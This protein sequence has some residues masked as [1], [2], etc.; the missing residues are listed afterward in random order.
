LPTINYADSNIKF[1]SKDELDKYLQTYNLEGIDSQF[2]KNTEELIFL[3][4]AKGAHF[5]KWWV[6]TP[7]TWKCPACE[8]QKSEIVRLNKHQDL[9][10]TLHE[11][12]DHM[13]DLVKKRFEE[14]SSKK[15]KVV[16]DEF[17]EKFSIRLSFA[18]ASYDNTVV[19]SDCNDADTKAKALAKTHTDFSYSPDDIKQ[20]IIVKNNTEHEINS[21]VAINIWNNQKDTFKLRM[22]FLNS[23]AAIA[24]DNKNWYKPSKKTAK[25]TESLGK[26]YIKKYGLD[27]IQY[28]PEKLLYKTYIYKGS[29]DKWRYTK[30]YKH[31]KLPTSGDIQHLSQTRGK[32][33]NDIDDSWI[34]PICER[35]KINCIQPSKKNPWVFLTVNKSFYDD[36]ELEYNNKKTICHECHRVS[37]HLHK[38]VDINSEID[39]AYYGLITQE[40]LKNCITSFKHNKHEIDNDYVNNLLYDLDN[41]FQY[42]KF[43]LET[44]E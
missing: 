43:Q 8:R 18:L 4:K 39:L 22:E 5:N 20:F 25:Q 9:S 21:E 24:A 19:C 31:S 35:T 29:R 13:A 2:S 36:S 44:D 14:L 42:L 23:I 12:H 15:S 30:E 41:R 37:L 6:L 17:S 11:H 16:A 28:E 33:W 7:T 40:E 1:Q 38:E 27:K 3:H 32:H 10:G 26:S 34:C